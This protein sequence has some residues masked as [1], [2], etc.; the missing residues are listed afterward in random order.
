MSF[1]MRATS[2]RK[3]VKQLEAVVVWDQALPSEQTKGLLWRAGDGGKRDGKKTGRKI[4]KGGYL[5]HC[6]NRPNNLTN[7]HWF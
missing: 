4:T 2:L 5:P 7:L 1:P 6:G 3:R